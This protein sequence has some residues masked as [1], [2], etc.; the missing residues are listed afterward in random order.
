MNF[1]PSIFTVEIAH[2]PT[3]AFQAK[4]HAEADQICQEWLQNHWGEFAAKGPGGVDLPPILKLRL[5][6]SAERK[7]YE[8]DGSGIEFLGDVKIIKLIDPADQSVPVTQ[9]GTA[10]RHDGDDADRNDNPS[11]P[12]PSSSASESAA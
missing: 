10:T 1:A 2:K 7:A 11:D 8:G 12:G 4:W 5:A 6:R 3:I 9:P